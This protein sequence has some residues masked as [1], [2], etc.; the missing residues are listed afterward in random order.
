MWLIRDYSIH[1]FLPYGMTFLHF[2]FRILKIEWKYSKETTPYCDAHSKLPD[3]DSFWAKTFFQPGLIY[4]V[5]DLLVRISQTHL[6]R[7][8]LGCWGQA[9]LDSSFKVEAGQVKE[10]NIWTMSQGNLF[11]NLNDK[12]LKTTKTKNLCSIKSTRLSS[13]ELTKT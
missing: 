2:S 7:S 8:V 9:A 1:K 6:G 12:C 11:R 4:T 5:A 10:V 3:R 13:T